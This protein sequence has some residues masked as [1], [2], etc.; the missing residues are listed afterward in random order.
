MDVTYLTRC[1]EILVKKKG[2]FTQRNNLEKHCYFN[3]LPTEIN[4]CK[5]SQSLCRLYS[6][7]FNEPPCSR[8]LITV[9][10]FWGVLGSKILHQNFTPFHYLR[11]RKSGKRNE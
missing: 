5:L 11:I 4:G 7:R 2:Y 3:K 1:V 6:A 9:S 8:S 10:F